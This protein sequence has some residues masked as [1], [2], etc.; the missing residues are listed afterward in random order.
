MAEV[1]A[2]QPRPRG[3]RLTIVTNAGGP[4]VLA[5][6]AL[7]HAGGV[8]AELSDDVTTALDD[9]LPAHWS[10][11][12]PIDILGDADP[13]RYRATLDVLV[14]DRNTDGLLVVL[15]PQAMTDP[16]GTAELVL[17]A[18]KKTTKPI[19]ASWMGG[20][21]IQE[22]ERMLNRA[23]IPTFAYPDTAVRMFNYMHQYQVRLDSLYETPQRVLDE[24]AVEPYERVRQQLAAIRKTGRTILTE[25][26]SKD[27]LAAYGIPILETYIAESAD[28]SVK[29]ADE[30]GYPVVIKIHSETITHK[31]DV[32]GV[33]LDLRDGASVRKAFNT[34]EANVSR[35]HDASDFLGVSVQP[36]LDLSE[37]YEIILGSSL[38]PQFGPTLLFGTGGTMVEVYKDRA[39]GLPPLTTTLARRMME[40]TLIY[41]ALRGIRGRDPVDIARLEQIMVQFSELVI[42][43]DSD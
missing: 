11:H 32:G 28:A 39:L 26:E 18:S 6:D 19:L 31:T 8:L 2:K 38:D 29:L 35:L 24:L 34:I 16:T 33:A 42:D 13:E 40:Q 14:E 25:K 23:N 30:M 37:S 12:N 5:T 36:M 21:D 1:L 15:T 27:L 7:I 17:E 4:G 41:E 3:P 43:P 10:H 22:G 9:V 20:E